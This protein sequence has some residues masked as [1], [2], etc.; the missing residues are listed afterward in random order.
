MT[1]KI[2]HITVNQTHSVHVCVHVCPYTGH[3][4]YK[5]V[6][7]CYLYLLGTGILSIHQVNVTFYRLKDPTCISRMTDTQCNVYACYSNT[8]ELFTNSLFKLFSSLL[9]WTVGQVGVIDHQN[10]KHHKTLLSSYMYAYNVHVNMCIPYSGKL[11]REKTFVNFV[12][13]CLS[14][15]GFSAKIN[16]HTHT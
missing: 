2:T 6:D 13:L 16:S 3:S 7:K 12:V 4:E 10:I 1:I 11:S 9:E 15:K 5:A 14:T 8:S